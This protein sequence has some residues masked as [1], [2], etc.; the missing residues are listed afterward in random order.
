MMFRI[1][2]IAYKSMSQLIKIGIFSGSRFPMIGAT[3]SISLSTI[4]SEL[5]MFSSVLDISRHTIVYGGGEA[6]LMGIIPS[7]YS[8]RGGTVLGV[9][10]SMFTNKYGIANFGKQFICPD[11]TTRQQR[12][13]ELSDL[14]IVLPGGVGT[15]YELMDVLVK[16]D[17]SLWVSTDLQDP[18]PKQ[19]RILVY[20]YNNCYSA[21]RTAMQQFVDS[22]LIAQS[23]F[24]TITW[25]ESISDVIAIVDKLDFDEDHV[26]EECA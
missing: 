5:K 16:N 15:L 3:S 14:F 4:T 17:L 7:H 21:L 18:P 9:D 8:A 23:T 22:G 25:C 20:N 6:G 2:Y 11:F 26:D 19:K 13:I 1:P 24:A 10:C 12:L